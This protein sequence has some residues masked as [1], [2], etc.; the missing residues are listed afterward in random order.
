MSHFKW[1]TRAGTNIT[2]HSLII[3]R[4]QLKM[5]NIPK[6]TVEEFIYARRRAD[7]VFEVP[8]LLV[9]AVD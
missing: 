4:W 2:P 7:H 9:D 5:S 8:R 3:C 6:Q 1:R